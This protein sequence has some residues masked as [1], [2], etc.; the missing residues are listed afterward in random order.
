MSATDDYATYIATG[1]T[2]HLGNIIYHDYN[3]SYCEAGNFTVMPYKDELTDVSIAGPHDTG[4]TG[5]NGDDPLLENPAAGRYRLKANSPLW[6]KG[7]P[8]LEGGFTTPGPFQRKA[9]LR[10]G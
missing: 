5:G 2:T 1:G 6:N 10:T 3:F 4:A 7:R 9:L 8:T